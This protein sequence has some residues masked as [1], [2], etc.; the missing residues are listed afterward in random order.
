MKKE[1]NTEILLIYQ[2]VNFLRWKNIIYEN[3]IKKRKFAYNARWMIGL[4]TYLC[5]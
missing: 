2:N 1:K 5:T 3:G 4:C